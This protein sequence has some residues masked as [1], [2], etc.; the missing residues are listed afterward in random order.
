MEIIEFQENNKH[1]VIDITES[2]DV[3][4][5]HFS[6]QPFEKENLQ[7]PQKK[8]FRLVE[9]QVTG[10]N[11]DDHHGS[12]HTGTNPGKKLRY[13]EH[14]DIRNH[15]GRKL[16]II[17][18]E[19]KL[20]VISHIQLFDDIPVIRSW[21][22]VKNNDY[23]PVGIEYL[24][25][26]A[27]TGIS[28]EGIMSW[29]EKSRIYVPHNTWYGEVQWRK[30][31][32]PE[33]GLS[34]VNEF[35]MKRISVGNTGSWSTKEYLP[36]GCYEN[37][38]SG[39]S[40]FW[41]IEH[42]GSWQWEISNIAKHLYLQL[43][44][45]TENENLWWKELKPGETFVSVPAA[46]AAVNGNMEEAVR[47][48]T[49][50]RRMIRRPNE[51]NQKL[52]VIFNDY[53]NCLFGDPT[54]E[55]LIPLIDAAAEAGCE[56]FCID[57]G[58]YSDGEW[59]VGVGEWLP[60]KQ[61]FPGGIKEVI[62]YIKS[63]GMIPGLW[64]EIE[65]MG[66][67]CPL[68]QV[69][70]D[71]WF[72][73][74][75]GQRIIDNGRYQLDFRNPEVCNHADKVVDRLINEYGVGYIKMDYN[76]NAGP[77]TDLD[78]DSFGD[79]MLQHN[80][81]YLSWLDDVFKRYPELVIENCGS[82]GLRMDYALLSRHSIQSCSDQTDYLKFARIVAASPTAVTPEQNAVWSYP[83]RYGDKE[84]VIFNMINAMLMRI[85]QSGHLAEISSERFDLIQEA[86]NYYKEI[87][88]DLRQGLPYWP[89]GIPTVS[90][91]W[92]SLAMQGEK[93]L[94]VAVWRLAGKD[95]NCL[96]PLAMLKGKA[97]SVIC[98]YP[99]KI[100]CK[101]NWNKES[102]YLS[103]FLENQNSARLFE[104]NLT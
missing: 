57:A 50:Y 62:N 97:V 89:L 88:E 77:G 48:M 6:S 41:Q 68:A 52:P 94:Y 49:K 9:I 37:I 75:H 72:F 5:I 7:E 22:E 61:R 78:S 70:P 73:M 60:S 31:T 24:S 87:R 12:K 18:S 84:E 45:P 14:K 67:N 20:M 2:G 102:G 23:N 96:L 17:Q 54:T 21:T 101:Y 56:Y 25:S 51:D 26:F 58:W 27:L 55:K 29:E 44:G 79:G 86:I 59:W 104:I 66:I 39:T 34:D 35:S 43:S 28:K 100:E 8:W 74:R 40:L 33:M 64:L 65:V 38:E 76:I 63:K 36:M 69:V 15:F 83:L 81:K 13:V 103:V 19:G 71:E 98:A 42:N 85:H 92:I 10:E 32:L 91:E 99:S 93:R 3:N 30:Y 4:F 53:M 46:I 80:R 90:D 16:E 47:A 1:L 82:G 95:P 11:H